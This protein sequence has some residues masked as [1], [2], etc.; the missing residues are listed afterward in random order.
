MRANPSHFA[1]QGERFNV[2][3]LLWCCLAVAGCDGVEPSG[4]RVSGEVTFQG[5]PLDHGTI[6]FSPTEDNT[7]GTVSGAGIKEGR[8]EVPAAT[9]LQPG[10]YIVRITSGEA[11]P[12]EEAAPGDSSRVVAR[13]R[14]PPE[15][16]ENSNQVIEVQAGGENKFNFQ[17]P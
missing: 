9:G 7:G 4:Y 1:G 12:L 11:Q 16:N 5:Q 13:E 15:F 17:I 14:I 10:K 6:N 2:A 3:R 8:Y